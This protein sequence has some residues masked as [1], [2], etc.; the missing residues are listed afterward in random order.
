MLPQKTP[1]T[2]CLEAKKL[3]Y[4]LFLH[5]GP[6]KSLEEA[7]A[8]RG[9]TPDQIIRTIVFRCKKDQFIIV[10]MPGEMR[11]SWSALRKYTGHSRIT[12]AS[13]REIL[14]LTGYQLGAVSPLGL[15]KPMRILVDYSI[16]NKDIISI[17]SGVRGLAVIMKTTDL[18]S[19]I[20]KYEVESLSE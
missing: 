18:L 9:Q 6:I 4:T 19:A 3:P 5:K 12:M 7:A 10:L 2:N 20:E 14:E 13:E 1:V 8:D 16:L 11:V 17:G 15:P